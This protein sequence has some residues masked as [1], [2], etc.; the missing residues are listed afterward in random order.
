MH[1]MALAEGILQLVE[2]TAL[3][4][5]ALRVKRVI[6][7]VGQLSA[8][9]PA[10]LAFCFSAVVKGSLAESAELEIHE[11]PGAGWCHSCEQTVPLRERFA[12]CP[13]CGAVPLQPTGGTEMRV[14]EIE[15]ESCDAL[16]INH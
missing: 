5:K 13:F 4:E 3:R 11:I 7:E 9:E 14:R 2:E 15:I 8:V 12:E 1:E 6:L 16:K 10:S